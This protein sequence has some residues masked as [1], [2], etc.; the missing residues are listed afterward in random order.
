MTLDERKEASQGVKAHTSK[1]R[2]KKQN[3]SSIFKKLKYFLS[4]IF[5]YNPISRIFITVLFLPFFFIYE[6][7]KGIKEAVWGNA[8]FNQSIANNFASILAFLHGI[9]YLALLAFVVSNALVQFDVL[10]Y[11][12]DVVVKRYL[13]PDLETYGAVDTGLVYLE[14]LLSYFVKGDTLIAIVQAF[15]AWMAYSI[16]FGLLSTLVAINE[17]LSAIRASLNRDTE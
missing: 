15:F 16:F 5:L 6:I 17:N 8:T 13:F 12:D 2:I 7:Y 9:V 4:T 11:M 3:K 10:R 1:I 14:V